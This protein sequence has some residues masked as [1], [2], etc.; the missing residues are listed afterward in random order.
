MDNKMNRRLW[1]QQVLAI[2]G[3]LGLASVGL[4][5]K[6]LSMAAVPT[7]GMLAGMMTDEAYAAQADEHVPNL[8]VGSGYGGAVTAL[9]LAQAGQPVTMLEMGRLWNT[10]GKDGKIFCKPFSPDDRAMWF[11]D[12]IT[13]LFS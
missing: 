5:G 8:V 10:P 13:A 2:G 12:R 11:K 1:G 6:V 3:Q 9:R 4:P 7:V